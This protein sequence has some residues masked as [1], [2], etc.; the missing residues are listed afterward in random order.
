MFAIGPIVYGTR[1]EHLRDEARR[2]WRVACEMNGI[3][4]R[5]SFVVFPE[6]CQYEARYNEASREYL[7]YCRAYANGEV[8]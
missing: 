5:S 6:G 3:D 1:R 7:E 2:A 8:D 4:P